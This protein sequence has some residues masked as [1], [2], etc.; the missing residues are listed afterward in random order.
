MRIGDR[1][2]AIADTLIEDS[3]RYLALAIADKLIEDS[4]R[5]TVAKNITNHETVEVNMEQIKEEAYARR[6][7]YDVLRLDGSFMRKD[8]TEEQ[9]VELNKQLDTLRGLMTANPEIGRML[10]IPN[11]CDGDRHKPVLDEM[12]VRKR[13]FI[14]VASNDVS[15]VADEKLKDMIEAL[16]ADCLATEDDG[17]SDAKE[18]LKDIAYSIKN[19]A[20]NITHHEEK[21]YLYYKRRDEFFVKFNEA[22]DK[23]EQLEEAKAQGAIESKTYN[24]LLKIHQAGNWKIYKIEHHRVHF[25][26]ARDVICTHVNPAA[27]INMAVN[28]GRFVLKFDLVN[29]KFRLDNLYNNLDLT[30]SLW[31]EALH[32]HVL[33]NDICWG[34]VSSKAG[35]Y[36]RT[37]QLVE[38][39]KLFDELL[40]TYNPDNPYVKLTYC[41]RAKR[42]DKPVPQ[43]LLAPE[44]LQKELDPEY[45]PAPVF[46]IGAKVKVT[47]ISH[48]NG[49]A[50]QIGYAAIIIEGGAVCSSCGEPKWVVEF[51][52]DM[53]TKYGV[54]SDAGDNIQIRCSNELELL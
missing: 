50:I 41:Q 9:I 40:A 51:E 29:R 37:T 48:N 1:A 15:D 23:L 25:Y 10:Y 4:M 49:N 44:W 26:S 16:K 28:M 30:N 38:W 19:C 54:Q 12:E 14:Y 5:Y 32:P 17:I 52:E 6:T 36:V 43:F 45:E 46:Q 22:Q 3:M 24:Q 42:N 39:V 34:N 13:A 7:V 35:E 20:E 8:K 27:G 53:H 47:N 33:L 31:K 11:F 21:V 2:I 18:K